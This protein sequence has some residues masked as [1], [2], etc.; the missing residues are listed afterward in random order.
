VLLAS[1]VFLQLVGTLLLGYWWSLLALGQRRFGQE[2]RR[3]ALG[4]L[5]GSVATALIVLGLVFD[6]ELVQNLLPLALLGFL[7]Q[8]LAVSHAWAHA[9]GWHPG[10][11]APLY[12]LLVMPPLNVLVVLPLS[13]LGLVDQW[14]DL[15]ASLR[16]R[17]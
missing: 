10:L 14:F 15:R 8:G 16:A 9:K 17:T 13:V 12:L 2:F 3:L 6:W 4:R 1:A 7:L 5:L 11:M